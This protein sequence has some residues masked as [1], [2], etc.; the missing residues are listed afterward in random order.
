MRFTEGDIVWAVVE[1]RLGVVERVYDGS[2]T[3]KWIDN[4]SYR[5][6]GGQFWTSQVVRGWMTFGGPIAPTGW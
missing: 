4:K 2:Y 5:S 3:V 6:W 1:K